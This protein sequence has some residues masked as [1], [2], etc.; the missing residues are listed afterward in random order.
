MPVPARLIA[1]SALALSGFALLAGASAPP[2]ILG[3]APAATQAASQAPVVRPS[4]ARANGTAEL[5]PRLTLSPDRIRAMTALVLQPYKVEA[6]EWGEI[7]E[8]GLSVQDMTG[9]GSQWSGGKQIFW[10]PGDMN[11]F[12]YDF[13]AVAG[14]LVVV[15]YT[16]APDY[17]DVQV[18]LGCYRKVGDGPGQYQY[19]GQIVRSYSGYSQT[20]ARQRLVFPVRNHPQCRNGD[21]WRLIFTMLPSAS[22]K[23]R[24]GIDSILVTRTMQIP[25]G[26]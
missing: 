10:A 2:V 25:P 19:L 24:G 22:G 20:V 5:P 23:V 11:S 15:N 13:S 6:E 4:A 1:A 7:P 9:W 14:V 18:K 17:A 16:T 21:A 26:S 3:P 8:L 12:K